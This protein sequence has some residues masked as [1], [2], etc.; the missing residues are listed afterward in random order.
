M[1][2]P[3]QLPESRREHI[4]RY[5][6]GALQAADAL[7]RI[8]TPLEDI[9]AALGLVTPQQLFELGDVP[10][11][12]AR[13]LRR[14]YGRVKGAL[15]V[16]ERV[17]YLDTEQCHA[18]RRFV[19][20]HELGH[21]ALRWHADAYYG[22]D[23]RTLD[24]DTR[25]ELE[26]EANAF[27]AELLFN[28]DAFTDQAHSSRLGLA[29]ALELADTFQ[30]SRHAAIRRY[31]EAA[32]RPCALLIF[33]RYPV[34]H[35][36]ERS[37]KV[38]HGIESAGFR[39]KYGPISACV[40]RKLPLKRWP[41]ASDAYTAIRGCTLTPVLAGELTTVDSRKGT[42]RLDYEVYSNT[43]LAFALLTPHRRLTLGTPVRAI[44]ST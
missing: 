35:D 32:P 39:E 38:L 13:K 25:D 2:A 26:A 5:A 19:F 34:S 30:T 17:I 22:D 21:D 44:W 16:R 27:S 31:V 12:L 1:A 10:P 36:G 9:N 28:L 42:V 8:P 7:G 33:G 20:G 43:H 3:A 15:G 40:P 29:P 11:E 18:Q 37:L 24:P 6:R 23:K 14:L 4:A 41:V